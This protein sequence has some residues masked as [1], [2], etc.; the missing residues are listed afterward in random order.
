MQQFLDPGDDVIEVQ[1]L[2]ADHFAAGEGEQLAGQ[3][4]RPF[5]GQGDLPEVV[6][7]Y[8]SVLRPVGSGGGG[9]FF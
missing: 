9:E 7:G 3:P 1:D 8:L 2:R 6:A 4:G 5:G